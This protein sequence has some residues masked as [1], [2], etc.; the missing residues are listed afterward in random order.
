M[1]FL[2]LKKIRAVDPSPL[3]KAIMQRL[4]KLKN[5]SQPEVSPQGAG[6]RLRFS[7][8]NRKKDSNLTKRI[9]LPD[10]ESN[11]PV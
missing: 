7:L 8:D 11:L 9:G 1:S 2:R 3:A 6:R 10:P 5:S 4:M